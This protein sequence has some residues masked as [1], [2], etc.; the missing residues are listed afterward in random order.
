MKH[1]YRKNELIGNKVLIIHS[2]FSKFLKHYCTYHIGIIKHYIPSINLIIIECKDINRSRF[3][4]IDHD[5]P[6]IKDEYSSKEL[7]QFYSITDG[8]YYILNTKEAEKQLNNDLIH[9]RKKSFYM[10]GSKLVYTDN[11]LVTTKERKKLFEH[12][13]KELKDESN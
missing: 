12:L 8:G 5:D 10:H 6:F 2:Y 3:I 13:L 1:Y 7:A 4:L 9:Y 11:S